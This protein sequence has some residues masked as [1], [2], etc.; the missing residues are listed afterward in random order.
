MPSINRN[1]RAKKTPPRVSSS[2]NIIIPS[3]DSV[4][5]SPV[6]PGPAGPT[7]P[8]GPVG[9]AGPGGAQGPAGP[10]GA[11]G[12]EGATGPAGSVVYKPANPSDWP[13]IPKNINEA[14]DQIAT[15][16]KKINN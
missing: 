5:P 7:G 8:A 2:K 6:V 1:V 16:F 10:G 4:V 3:I 9:P 15:L 11:Q 14:L 13:T 12:P